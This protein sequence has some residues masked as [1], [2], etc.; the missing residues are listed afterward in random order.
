M[1]E[2][3]PKHFY[4]KILYKKIS[5]HPKRQPLYFIYAKRDNALVTHKKSCPTLKHKG[6]RA[7]LSKFTSININM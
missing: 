3:N 1:Y 7:I 6:L 4:T 5:S 2:H